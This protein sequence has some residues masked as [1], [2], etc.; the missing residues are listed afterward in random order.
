MLCQ[1]IEKK[2][3]LVAA[4]DA[5]QFFFFEKWK[6]HTIVAKRFKNWI[7][8]NLN[9]IM[10]QPENRNNNS[11]CCFRFVGQAEVWEVRGEESVGVCLLKYCCRSGRSLQGRNV[12]SRSEPSDVSLSV[13]GNL[14]PASVLLF[15]EA[16]LQLLILFLSCSSETQL[17][18]FP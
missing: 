9:V 8:L 3:I 12:N 5:L 18:Q 1:F 17:W 2:I 10:S 13:W 4:L 16:H 6:N 11:G 7:R 15:A 14:H